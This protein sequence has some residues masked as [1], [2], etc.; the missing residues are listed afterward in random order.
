MIHMQNLSYTVY[1]KVYHWNG[2]VVLMKFSSLAAPEFRCSQWW[3]FRH[4]EDISVSMDDNISHGDSANDVNVYYIMELNM[5]LYN[6][7]I[8]LKCRLYTTYTHLLVCELFSCALHSNI[9][10]RI[11]ADHKLIINS[12]WGTKKVICHILFKHLLVRIVTF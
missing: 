10:F 6:I 1:C 11:V 9:F 7:L 8:D 3:K 4:N 12:H 2:N 5:T